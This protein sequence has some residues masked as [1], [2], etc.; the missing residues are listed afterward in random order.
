VP[1]KLYWGSKTKYTPDLIP[2]H[3]N[4]VF[5][6]SPASFKEIASVLCYGKALAVLTAR[7]LLCDCILEY[8][9]MKKINLE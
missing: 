7:K 4:L 8:T 5:C 1:G 2:A 3:A 6:T 9:F